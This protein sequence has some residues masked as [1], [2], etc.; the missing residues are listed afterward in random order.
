MFMS[1][2]VKVK[3]GNEMSAS[4]GD[5][6]STI[7]EQVI[8]NYSAVRETEALSISGTPV[9]MTSE[10]RDYVEYYLDNAAAIIE[11]NRKHNAHLPA[12]YMSVDNLPSSSIISNEC[13]V[14]KFGGM[15]QK[16]QHFSP[17]WVELLNI[18]SVDDY[19]GPTCV[20]MAP[21]DKVAFYKD[22]AASFV[23]ADSAYAPVI[24]KR[25]NESVPTPVT[26][27]AK[28]V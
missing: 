2:C 17:I 3:M 15:E 25:Q 6:W 14:V 5:Q 13:K 27:P 22:E 16:P 18:N 1:R 11:L 9:L 12:E 19:D 10:A 28:Y 23:P 7:K 26:V 20:L 21:S 24:S 4:A 8:Q